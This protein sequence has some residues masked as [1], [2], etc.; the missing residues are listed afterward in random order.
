MIAG[1][2]GAYDEA[3]QSTAYDEY[4]ETQQAAERTASVDSPEGP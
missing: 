1:A 2:K 4:V 3:M